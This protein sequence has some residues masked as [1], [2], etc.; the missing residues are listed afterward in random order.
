MYVDIPRIIVEIFLAIK[1]GTVLLPEKQEN[2]QVCGKAKRFS[3][4]VRYV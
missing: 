4:S 3:F 2:D 1:E